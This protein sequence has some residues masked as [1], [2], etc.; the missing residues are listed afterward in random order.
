M[1]VEVR[2]SGVLSKQDRDEQS[3]DAASLFTFS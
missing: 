1:S 2:E 3:D